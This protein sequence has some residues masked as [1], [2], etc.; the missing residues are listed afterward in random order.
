MGLA[1]H[2]GYLFC[3]E[4][5]FFVENIPKHDLLKLGFI[6]ICSNILKKE[7]TTI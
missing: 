4:P 1:Y 5:R 7:L 2:E 3:I 6:D